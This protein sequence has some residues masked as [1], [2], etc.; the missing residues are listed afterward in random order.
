MEMIPD[1]EQFDTSHENRRKMIYNFMVSGLAHADDR[2]AEAV[3][4]WK[5]AL[6]ERDEYR[7]RAEA[8]E[9]ELKIRKDQGKR[10]MELESKIR[11]FAAACGV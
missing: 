10:V 2:A 7:A 8:A 6:S 5:I 1:F 9:A 4:D 3:K 11:S